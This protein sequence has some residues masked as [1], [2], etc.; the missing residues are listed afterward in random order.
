MIIDI[1]RDLFNGNHVDISMLIAY[2]LSTIFIVIAILPLHEL[3]HAWMAYK[4]G[5]STAKNQGRLTF[6][7]LAS[8]DPIG[9][10]CI[11]LFGFGWAKPVPVNSNF[12][13]KPKVGMAITAAAGPVSNLLAALVGGFI[14]Y[15]VF[16]F[17]P[18]GAV[19]NFFLYF[20]S[21]YIAINVA[22]A[23]F[24]LLPIPPLDGSKIL[25]LFLSERAMYSFYKY[26]NYIFMVL[27]FLMFSGILSVPLSYAQNFFM[28]IIYTIAKLPFNLFGANI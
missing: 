9:A 23:V 26:Q 21:Y 24:N 2:I 25:G 8:V 11:L 20:F 19:A 10:L 13:K 4:L 22:L 15:A 3:A 16:V 6:N 28:D 17:A 18:F 7:P 12:F 1:I 14:Y 5:D 27:I